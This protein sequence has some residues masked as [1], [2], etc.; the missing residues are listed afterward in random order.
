MERLTLPR[1]VRKASWRGCR[2]SCSGRIKRQRREGSL[3]GR[4]GTP[5][6]EKVQ[7]RGKACPILL[8]VSSQSPGGQSLGVGAMIY[9][10]SHV[11][12]SRRSLCSCMTAQ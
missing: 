9:L 8:L 2:L 12:E 6:G 1:V 5:A 3:G 4:E 7:V 10:P 11:S